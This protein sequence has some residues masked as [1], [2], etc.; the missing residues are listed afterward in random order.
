MGKRFSAKRPAVFSIFRKAVQFTAV[1][2]SARAHARALVQDRCT[3]NCQIDN[4]SSKKGPS[5]KKD[6]L[7]YLSAKKCVSVSTTF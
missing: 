7:S 3:S 1:H 2:L 4:L 5:R 6:L